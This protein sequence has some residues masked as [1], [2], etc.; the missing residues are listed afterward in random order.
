MDLEGS[1]DSNSAMLVDFAAI[2]QLVRR[3]RPISGSCPSARA[4][5]PRFLQ[6]PPPAMPLRF[7]IT[8][9]HQDVKRT[10]ISTLSFMNGVQKDAGLLLA[11]RQSQ[12]ME[13]QSETQVGRANQNSNRRLT[14]PCR[15]LI[16]EPC[17]V[18]WP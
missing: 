7:A 5:A 18:T 11:I 12:E 15:L 6:T 10:C 3:R 2:C 13:V 1:S 14:C 9:P 8:S 17:D 4:F 16:C